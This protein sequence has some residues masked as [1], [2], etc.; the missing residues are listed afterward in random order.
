MHLHHYLTFSFPQ[1]LRSQIDSSWAVIEIVLS[2]RSQCLDE[3]D[4]RD[5]D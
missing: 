4:Y 1:S 3:S 2:M 5:V